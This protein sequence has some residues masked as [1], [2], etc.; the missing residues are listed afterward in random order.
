LGPET[1]GVVEV[2]RSTLVP[3]EGTEGEPG[4]KLVSGRG[5]GVVGSVVKVVVV[6]AVVGELVPVGWVVTTR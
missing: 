6:V 1:E 2:T 4:T 5:G 3:A